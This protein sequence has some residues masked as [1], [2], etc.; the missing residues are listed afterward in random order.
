MSETRT[1]FGD[2]LRRL[3]SAAALS[4]EA[5]AER[6]GLSRNGIS[7]LERGLHPAP[8]LETVRM[9][10]DGLALGEADRAALLTAA[11]PARFRDDRSGPGELPPV[12]LPLPVT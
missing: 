9:L 8:R 12:S 4:Q 11:R 7:D 6:A 3:R 10:A 2:L 1:S 5:L